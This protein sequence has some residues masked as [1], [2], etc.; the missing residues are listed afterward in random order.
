MA[1]RSVQ[2]DDQITIIS[3]NGQAIRTTVSDI[4]L[5]GRATKGTRLM[6]L[7]PGDTVASVARLAAADLPAPEATEPIT[8]VATE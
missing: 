3:V 5:L 1:V 6:N 2:P 7:K 8:E 4:R